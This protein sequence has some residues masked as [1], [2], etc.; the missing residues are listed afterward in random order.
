MI[1]VEELERAPYRLPARARTTDPDV[2]GALAPPWRPFV[3]DDQD[4]PRRQRPLYRARRGDP[5]ADAVPLLVVAAV[6]A[7]DDPQGP[8]RVLWRGRTTAPDLAQYQPAWTKFAYDEPPGPRREVIRSR[9]VDPDL[10]GRPLLPRFAFLDETVQFPHRV[11]MRSRQGDPDPILMPITVIQP[12][13]FI[14]D[15][16]VLSRRIPPIVRTLRDVDITL[17]FWFPTLVSPSFG[18]VWSIANRGKAGAVATA[19][20]APSQ[21]AVFQT[22]LRSMYFGLSGPAIGSATAVVRDGQPGIGAII[23]QADLYTAANNRDVVSL[24]EVD[25]RATAGNVLTVEFLAGTPSDFQEV[26]AQGD[27]ILLGTPYGD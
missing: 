23:F 13:V 2:I 18:V 9:T 21:D 12:G 11:I 10:V 15:S 3:F 20:I 8:R 5:D 14:E 19:S 27:L 25:L 1:V 7:L 16:G 26:S 24:P 4:N 22:R 6:V 17:G